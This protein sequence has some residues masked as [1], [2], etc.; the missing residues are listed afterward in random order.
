MGLLSACDSEGT[1]AGSG[2]SGGGGSGGVAGCL[3]DPQPTFLLKIKERDGGTVPPDTTID[4]LWSA[5]QEPEVHLNDP[6]TW[7][8]LET[9]SLSCDLDATQ[10][11]PTDLKML[12]CALWTGSPVEVT[13]S[14]KGYET[15]QHT[16]TAEPSS[17]CNPEPTSIEVELGVAP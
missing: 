14:A 5:G 15:E 1:T 17:E 4:V 13:V 2:G 8:S 16:F 11:P 6:S 3:R 9:S 12:I 7:P 10:P